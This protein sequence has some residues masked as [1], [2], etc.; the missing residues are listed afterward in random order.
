MSRPNGA[1]MTNAQPPPL[2]LLEVGLPL[3]RSAELPTGLAV[4]LAWGA[5][6]GDA[7]VLLAAG[8]WLGDVVTAAGGGAW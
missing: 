5:A 7:V 6:V 3:S 8:T 1:K 4:W 2:L